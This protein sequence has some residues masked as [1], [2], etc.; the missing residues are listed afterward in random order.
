MIIVLGQRSQIS[1]RLVALAALMGFCLRNRI[2]FLVFSLSDYRQVFQA[3]G[4]VDGLTLGF[5]PV[6]LHRLIRRVLSIRIVRTFLTLLPGVGILD[7]QRCWADVEIP[8]L[9]R[10]LW[11]IDGPGDWCASM[12]RISDQEATT[13]R[14]VLSY[15]ARFQQQASVFHQ[16]LRSKCD[17]LIGVHARR[18]DYASHRD[19]RWFYAEADYL[20]WIDQA[21]SA[22]RATPYERI[23][24]VVCSN[25]PGFLECANRAD[26]SVSRLGSA[27]A[28]QLLL[29]MCDLILGPP[30]TFSVWA[31]FLSDT[32]LLHIFSRDQRLASS[33]VRRSTLFYGW[34]PRVEPED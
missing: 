9:K 26:L 30:S 6:P 29:S 22:L 3:G 31:A 27:A 25:E 23:H 21:T 5:W 33:Q 18:G 17:R 28:D 13:I 2:R 12:P 11:I 34:Q 7:Q 32:A 16:A 19:G 1:N 4:T 20:K 14:R 10:G 15:H 24:F 8:S